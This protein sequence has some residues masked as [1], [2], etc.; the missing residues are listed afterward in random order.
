MNAYSFFQLQYFFRYKTFNSLLKIYFKL[1]NQLY[2]IQHFPMFL[3]I[4]NLL[5]FGL[6]HL[7]TFLSFLL[8]IKM[9]TLKEKEYNI[10]KHS[11]QL[12]VKT[13]F[14]NVETKGI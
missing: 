13:T 5:N 1:R 11:F 7:V 14:C 10:L 4:I 8:N 12:Y 6:V 9:E 2:Y 3:F